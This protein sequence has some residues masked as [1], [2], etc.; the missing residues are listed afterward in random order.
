MGDTFAQALLYVLRAFGASAMNVHDIVAVLMRE[1][2]MA[3]AGAVF[4]ST[5]QDP[6]MI[7]SRIEC[8]SRMQK[9]RRADDL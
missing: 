3:L 9:R 8:L 7:M 5:L 4:R 1:S 2:A 6:M